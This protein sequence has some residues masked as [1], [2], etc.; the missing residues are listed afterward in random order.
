MPPPPTRGRPRRRIGSAVTGVADHRSRV[1]ADQ[2]DQRHQ[3]RQHHQLDHTGVELPEAGDRPGRVSLGLATGQPESALGHSLVQP[4]EVPTG[5][6]HA[7]A[8]HHRPGR[9]N[10]KRAQEGE[11]RSHEGVEQRHAQ[12]GQRDHQEH[13]GHHR[14][15]LG[16]A[17]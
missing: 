4:E 17:T 16:Q 14:H 5:Q 9:R 10:L 2:H 8:G 7:Q 6:D 1:D 13:T 3:R 12:A 15:G 11:K